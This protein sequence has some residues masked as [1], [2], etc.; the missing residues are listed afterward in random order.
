MLK[1]IAPS[2]ENIPNTFSPDAGVTVKAFLGFFLFSL[3]S[4]IALW[5]PVDRIRHLFTIKSILVPIAAIALF[6]WA[7]V[8]AKG[9]GPI[10]QQPATFKS[11]GEATWVIIASI[12]S[13]FGN[14]A[15]LV[16]IYINIYIYL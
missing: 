13:C 16:C 14:M 12:T 3:F 6:V 8:N 7:I 11:T 1:A 2:I 4:L 10:I 5:F 15:A 9:L